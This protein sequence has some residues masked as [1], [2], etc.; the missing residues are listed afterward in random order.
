MTRVAVV[1][2]AGRGIGA[3]VVDQLAGSGWRVLAV[4]I[5]ADIPGAG[6]A[7]ASREDLA[8]VAKRWPE[9]VLDLVA[10][11][12]DPQAMTEAVATAERE[13]GGLDAAVA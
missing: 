12:R 10:D 13:F 2:G 7:L 3:A 8:A 9:R 4:D 1:T 5:C 6:Y 11:V